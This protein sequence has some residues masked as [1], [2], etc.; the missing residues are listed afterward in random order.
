MLT[1][2]VDAH[3]DCRES[4]EQLAPLRAAKRRATEALTPL[5]EEPA[6]VR[7]KGPDEKGRLLRVAR[8][9]AKTSETPKEGKLGV[10]MFLNALKEA[11]TAVLERSM[12]VQSAAFEKTLVEELRRRLESMMSSTSSTTPVRR[13]IQVRVVKGVLE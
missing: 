13:N 8:A 5:L 11:V 1:Q 12:S 10:R 7:V 2:Y 4:R 3:R 9:E 6:I